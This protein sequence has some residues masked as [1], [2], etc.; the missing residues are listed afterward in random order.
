MDE[1]REHGHKIAIIRRLRAY[2]KALR[3]LFSPITYSCRKTI[4]QAAKLIASLIQ[5][6]FGTRISSKIRRFVKKIR[7]KC[8]K[9]LSHQAIVVVF[10]CSTPFVRS[11]LSFFE[12]KNSD[13]MDAFLLPKKTKSSLILC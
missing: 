5:D 13:I 6:S 11:Q 2:I 10:L 12:D 8:R 1:Y 9:A 4:R 7:N 3:N